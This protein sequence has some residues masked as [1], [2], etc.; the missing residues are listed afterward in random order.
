MKT[1]VV[2]NRLELLAPAL[3]SSSPGLS[4]MT[5][6]GVGVIGDWEYEFTMREALRLLPPAV[7]F[8]L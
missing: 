6:R 5:V 7:M 1:G 3:R 2:L 4:L 8:G